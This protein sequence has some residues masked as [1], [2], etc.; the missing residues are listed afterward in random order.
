MRM[1]ARPS[2][3]LVFG[4]AFSRASRLS[5]PFAFSSDFRADSDSLNFSNML[6]WKLSRMS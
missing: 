1:A 5:C 6:T 3:R 4:S 2:R